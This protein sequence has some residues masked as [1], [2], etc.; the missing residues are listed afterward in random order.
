MKPEPLE[1][2][3]CTSLPPLKLRKFSCS[4]S[5]SNGEGVRLHG[6]PSCSD[7]QSAHARLTTGRV[8]SAS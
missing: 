7:G 5:Q 8:P 2:T 6:R 4:S 3:L 1:H